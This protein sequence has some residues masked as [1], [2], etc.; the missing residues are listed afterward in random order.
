MQGIVMRAAQMLT[1]GFNNCTNLQLLLMA[2][3]AAPLACLHSVGLIT[4]NKI[5]GTLITY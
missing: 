4:L 2:M 1:Q 3:Q 5:G